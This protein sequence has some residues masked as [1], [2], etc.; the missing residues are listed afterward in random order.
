MIELF[1][2]FAFREEIEQKYDNKISQEMSGAVFEVVSRVFKE[3]CQKKIT[4]PGNFKRFVLPL[5]L[6]CES[7]HCYFVCKNSVFQLKCNVIFVR[8]LIFQG[9]N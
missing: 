9:L 7:V 8:S 1:L 6:F 5:F 2:F 4:V 3:I